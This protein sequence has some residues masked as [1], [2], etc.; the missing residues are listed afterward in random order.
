VAA[1]VTGCVVTSVGPYYTKENLLSEPA[2]LG[3][4]TNIKSPDQVWKF[5]PGGELSSRFTLIE[6]VLVL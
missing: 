6:P 2:L 1:I 4:W 5:E 3:N